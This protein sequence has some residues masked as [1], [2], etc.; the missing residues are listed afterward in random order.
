M[1][2]AKEDDYCNY[3]HQPKKNLIMN[4][5]QQQLLAQIPLT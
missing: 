1:S 5:Q 4:Q 2:P 3:K